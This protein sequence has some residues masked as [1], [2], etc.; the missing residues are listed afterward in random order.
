MTGEAEV[1][2]IVP[3][4][5]IDQYI[6]Q[7]ISSIIM[8]TYDK[9]QIVLV[10]D[11]STDR[12][13]QIC[14]QYQK[15]DVRIVVIHKQNE[16]LVPARKTGLL[17]ATGKYICYVDGDDWIEPDFIE[18]LLAGMERAGTELSV[19]D[20]FCDMEE[21]SWKVQERQQAGVYDTKELI[22]TMLY[23]GEF[24]EFGISQFV[25][26]KL[27]RRDV[28]YEIQMQVDDRIFCGEDVAVTYPYILKTRKIC[29]LSYAG[30]H[31]RQRRGSMTSGYDANEQMRNRIL[32]RYLAD[33]FQ[34]SAYAD[35]LYRQLN[36][37]AKNLFLARQIDCFDTP[38][39]RG[40]L[41]P[42][43]GLPENAR[44]VI[45]GAGKL[46]QS[47]YGYLE[48]QTSVTIIDWVD[49][50]Y[51][52]YQKG[53]RKVNSPENLKQFDISSYDW[54]IIG[55]CS[56][57]TAEKIKEYLIELHIDKEKIKW[58]RKAFIQEKTWILDT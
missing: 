57:K 53:D 9:L 56:E 55:V 43:G 32:I 48:R 49:K 46:G 36:Q 15:K 7:C 37:Y 20:Y 34:S 6:E 13:G 27:F 38:K 45:Y 25:W 42:Y 19:A 14:D 22:S 17:A 44:V 24:Y 58:L 50:N 40:L 3:I 54:V 39:G 1:S 8:Q 52:R 16:G 51:K 23:T 30:Y 41:T 21:Y 35:N 31:Y 29:F 28:L 2:V 12:S 10:D 33:I 11:G 26:A 4:Y 5:N 47:I 18:H